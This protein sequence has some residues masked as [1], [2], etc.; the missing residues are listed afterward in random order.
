MRRRTRQSGGHEHRLGIHGKVHQRAALEFEDRLALVAVLLV[1]PARILDA[2]VCER[3]LQLHRGYRNAVQ[4]Q[5]DIQRLVGGACRE[6]EL[7]GQAQ[8]VGGVAGFKLRI[9]LVRRLEVRRTQR[10]T[11]AFEPV[12]QHGQRAVDVHPLAQIAED[13]LAGPVAMKRLQPGPLLWLGLADEGQDRLGERS[14]ALGRS[15]L[16][17]RT[18]SR[19]PEDAPRS[20][21]QKRARRC[22]SFHC[23]TRMRDSSTIQS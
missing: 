18:R 5:R 8:P 14:H 2:L 15:R 7:A 1:L 20:R 22:A 23:R 9:Q 16:R 11:V 6:V 19:S 17:R 10:S 4:A 13:L 21:F 12:S 3:I